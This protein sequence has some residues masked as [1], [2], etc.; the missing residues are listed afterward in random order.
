MDWL[1]FVVAVIGVI[2]YVG[3]KFNGGDKDD[4]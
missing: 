4:Y 3:Y 2:V 1:L